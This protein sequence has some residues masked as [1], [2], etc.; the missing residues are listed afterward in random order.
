HGYPII[1][2]AA[3]GGGGRGMRIVR[4][5]SHVKE[6]YE[7]AKSE[8]KAAFGNDEVYVEKFIENPKHI[9]V[10]IIGDEHGNIVHLHERDCSVQR[11]L[12]KVVE[13]ARSVY[14]PKD[15]RNQF[16]E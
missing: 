16:S 11:R 3:L 13:M 12:K 2:K 7:R 15:R 9:E 6:A 14:L 1:I 4:H 8:A 5:A 10:Q